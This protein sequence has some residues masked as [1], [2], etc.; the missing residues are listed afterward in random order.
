[1]L[2]K[3]AIVASI[4]AL[5]GLSAA[6]P[7]VD[8]VT[9]KVRSVFEGLVPGKQR[10]PFFIQF[11]NN[12]DQDA[13]GQLQVRSSNDTFLVPIDLARR[14]K[15]EVPV[16]APAGDGAIELEYQSSLGSF[17]SRFFPTQD[18]ANFRLAT[19]GDSSGLLTF[20]KIR[21]NRQGEVISDSQLSV[22]HCTP[23]DAP[24][25]PAGYISLDAVILADG[26]ERLNPRQIEALKQ[27]V[28]QGGRLLLSGGANVPALSM[29][30][31]QS[32]LPVSDA[33]AKNFPAGSVLVS[34][35]GIRYALT[36]A[37]TMMVGRPARGTGVAARIGA[38]AVTVARPVGLGTVVFLGYN[39]FVEPLDAHPNRRQFLM[40]AL[41]SAL[42]GASALRV[43]SMTLRGREYEETF[44]PSPSY[45]SATQAFPEGEAELYPHNGASNFGSSFE[46]NPFAI[47]LI[48]PSTI[49]I[50]FAAFFFVV[51]P[52]NFLILK[53]FKR[54]EWAWV[55]TPICSLAFAGVLLSFAQG[56]YRAEASRSFHGFVVQD[57]DSGLRAQWL[58]SEVFL[59]RGGSYDLTIP[60]T[61][62]IVAGDHFTGQEMYRMHQERRTNLTAV[63]NGLMTLPRVDVPNLAFRESIYHRID[64]PKLPIGLDLRVR[65][66]KLEGKIR[67]DTPYLLTR[68][69]LVYRGEVLMLDNMAQRTVYDLSRVVGRGQIRTPISSGR[70]D[71]QVVFYAQTSDYDPGGVGVLAK[72][73]SNVTII[74]T[75]TVE[76]AP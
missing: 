54:L 75:K 61:D 76:V 21:R 49:A 45:P 30:N 39:P 43:H 38:Q 3:S 7:A 40:D 70:F 64:T 16:Y 11:Q 4:V 26:S 69:A 42:Y 44:Y 67:N 68:V 58:K 71:G 47:K 8:A 6:A 18:Y 72:A 56:L 23:E 5:M 74:C 10:M 14:S 2:K 50:V 46:N 32:V 53:L 31:W 17:R 24:D 66:G 48:P 25:R 36:E 62:Q 73:N 19:I 27:Y 35:S 13:V 55:T 52:L 12:S 59:P 15:K 22:G 65:D 34:T 28:V 33:T 37:A 51:L 41:R 9:L 60:Q 20:L 1:M 57:E 63:D 29:P